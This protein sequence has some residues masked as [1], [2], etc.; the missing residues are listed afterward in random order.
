MLT[1]RVRQRLAD[2]TAHVVIGGLERPDALAAVLPTGAVRHGRLDVVASAGDLLDVV[3]PA[4]QAE[5]A[6]ELHRAMH[7][8]A[9]GPPDLAAPGG[10]LPSATRPLLMGV[11]NVTP[12]SFSDGGRHADTEEAVRAGLALWAA[13]ADLVDVGGESTRPGAAPVAVEVECQRVLPVIATLAEAGVRTSVDT[14]KAEVA[15][16]AVEAGAVLVNDVSAGAFDPELLPCVAG[17]GVP[18]VLMHCRGTPRTMQ[19]DPRYLDVVAEVFDHLATRLAE[20]EQ[21]G[22]ARERVVVDPGLGFGKTTAHNLALVRATRE[23]T[24]LGRPVLVGASRK[25]FLGAVTGVDDPGDRLEASLAVAA[26]AVADGARVLRVH[27]VAATR[28]AVALAHAVAGSS[29]GG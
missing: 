19:R 6:R 11:L 27:D 3:A 22:I 2:G 18:Y 25:S 5:L 10:V 16:A 12:D 8:F 23:L 21:L 17:L 20:L 29:A 28:R 1:V 24:S 13:G 9:A 14:S 4:Q 26:L 7:A 15:R